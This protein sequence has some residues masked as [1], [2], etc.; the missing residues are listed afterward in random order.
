MAGLGADAGDL[1]QEGV[2]G[3]EFR[4]GVDETGDFVFEID[5]L[6]FEESGEAAVLTAGGGGG[7]VGGLVIFAGKVVDELV[8]VG[9]PFAEGVAEGSRGCAGVGRD[10]LP[11][12]GEEASVDGV[13]FGE[14]SGTCPIICVWNRVL[15]FVLA[16]LPLSA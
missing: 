9:E 4:V 1:L 6:F 16:R 10:V 3:L 11:E 15:V 13:A 14:E 7:V 5:D 12:A 8:A 2:G